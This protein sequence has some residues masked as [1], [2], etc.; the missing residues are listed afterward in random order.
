MWK[1]HV[2]C[3]LLDYIYIYIYKI[4]KIIYCGKCCRSYNYTFK[5]VWNE[6]NENNAVYYMHRC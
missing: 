1:K 4:Y 5:T 6:N 2:E 3:L